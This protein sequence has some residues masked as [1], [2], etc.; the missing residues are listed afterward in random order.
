MIVQFNVGR[1][2]AMSKNRGSKGATGAPATI[3]CSPVPPREKHRGKQSRR[4]AVGTIRWKAAPR[5]ISL[6]LVESK[7]RANTPTP[8]NITPW[9]LAANLPTQGVHRES[10]HETDRGE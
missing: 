1:H 4:D 2:G 3:S 8:H 7:Y 10:E 9:N 6:Y 5:F